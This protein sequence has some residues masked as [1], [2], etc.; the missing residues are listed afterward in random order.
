MS[1]S[2]MRSAS[3]C[4]E[5]TQAARLDGA[6][7]TN[8]NLTGATPPDYGNGFR[9]KFCNTTMPDGTINNDDC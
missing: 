6:N 3:F 5:R 9:A 4:D 7:L 8:A 1:S 2:T